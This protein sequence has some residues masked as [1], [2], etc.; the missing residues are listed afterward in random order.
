VAKDTTHAGELRALIDSEDF[1]GGEFKG[2]VIEIHTKLR[3]N[4]A[5][6]NIEKLISL[7][8]PDNPVEIV[9]H[10]NMLKEGWD[11]TNVYTIAAVA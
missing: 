11:V 6:E 4:E 7:E 8:H 10:V 1:R 5:D 2:K 9:I 3:G